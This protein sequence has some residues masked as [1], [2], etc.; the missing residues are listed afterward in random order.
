MFVPCKPFQPGLMFSSYAGAYP[1]DALHSKV[2]SLR[3]KFSNFFNTAR[4]FVPFQPRLRFAI[5]AGAFQSE[6]LHSRT[7]SWP[8]SQTLDHPEKALPGKHA[9]AYY[10]K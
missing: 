7:D 10:K 6:A 9:V 8:Y 5:K 3:P 2:G 1:S 4:V